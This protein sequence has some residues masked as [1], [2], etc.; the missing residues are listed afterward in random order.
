MRTYLGSV[1]IDSRILDFGNRWTWMVSFTP[2]PPNT[3]G[4]SPRQP[5][6]RRLGGPQS[7][8]GHT[9]TC[10]TAIHCFGLLID[11]SIFLDFLF[12]AASRTALR[13]TQPPT[14]G[15]PGALSLWVKRPGREANHSPPSS[16][17]V[18]NAWS[19][20][21]TPQ[22]A[23]RLWCLVNHS[24]N[25]TLYVYLYPFLRRNFSHLPFLSI[26]QLFVQL[27]FVYTPVHLFDYLTIHLLFT[28][29]P[30]HSFTCPPIQSLLRPIIFL[31]IRSLIY[32][33]VQSSISSF[34][35]SYVK[36]FVL[37]LKH[38]CIYWIIN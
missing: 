34:I 24:D 30:V 21:S 23:F 15:V 31:I 11:L 22:Y 17:E 36:S 29:S 4:K 18:T 27:S 3:Q 2:R 1:G 16:A 12:T 8:S 9:L 20:T 37:I 6:D 10:Q 35:R 14:E 25:F 7:R 13:P 38:T 32:V 26:V 28:F 19:Y 33:F 5:L